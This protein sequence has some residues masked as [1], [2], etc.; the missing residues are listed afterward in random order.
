MKIFRIIYNSGRELSF[1]VILIHSNINQLSTENGTANIFISRNC[2]IAENIGTYFRFSCRGTNSRVLQKRILRVDNT[3]L[4]N[5]DFT[6]DEL[7]K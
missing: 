7:V 6:K 1:Q 3:E 5:V 4:S 2:S